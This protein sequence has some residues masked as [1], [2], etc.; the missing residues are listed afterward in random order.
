MHAPSQQ[1]VK[2]CRISQKSPPWYQAFRE[3]L[4]SETVGANQRV[5]LVTFSRA[6]PGTVAEHRKTWIAQRHIPTI[7]PSPPHQP[8]LN[9]LPS[10]SSQVPSQKHRGNR[11]ATAPATRGV[12]GGQH[13]R[14]E[15]SLA[16]YQLC[17]QAL[18]VRDK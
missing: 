11:K 17:R 1:P 3:S 12:L 15:N 9:L 16:T 2:R 7:C 5:Y 8:M 14:V 18:P 13:L 10:P 4:G 6:F